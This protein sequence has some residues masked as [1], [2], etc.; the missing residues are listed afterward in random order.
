MLQ[1]PTEQWGNG[2]QADAVFQG[3]AKARNFLRSFG[4]FPHLGELLTG[5]QY[6][7]FLSLCQITILYIPVQ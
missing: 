4:F 2:P 3:I 6:I 1:K 5:I 7:I